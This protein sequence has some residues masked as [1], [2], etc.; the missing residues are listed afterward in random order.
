MRAIGRNLL[1]GLSAVLPLSLTV[2]LVVWFVQNTE[3]LLRN[4]FVFFLPE[5]HYVTGLGFVF[6]LGVLYLAGV[7]VQVFVFEAIW[8]RVEGLVERVPVIK[9]VYGAIRDFTDF[10]WH[11]DATSGSE[12]A[13][14]EIAEGVRLIGMITGA[15]PPSIAPEGSGM[16]AV[17]L[18]MSYQLGGY[19][20]VIPRERV[21]IL[22]V[23]VEDA[24][25]FV[26]TAGIKKQDRA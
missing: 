16:V 8:H 11:R 1:R 6:G 14:V 20:I 5:S 10:F 24:M 12:V 17:Y 7:L 21:E 2:W 3:A 13:S 23:P 18:P 26:L 15:P 4:V 22:D 9:T 25:R 19:T